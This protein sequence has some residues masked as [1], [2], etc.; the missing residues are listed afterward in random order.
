MSLALHPGVSLGPFSLG[1]V[2]TEAIELISA[3]YHSFA[4]GQI[5]YDGKQAAPSDVLLQIPGLGVCLRFEQVTQQLRRIDFWP[6]EFLTVT[7]KTRVVGCP[8]TLTSSIAGPL[9][10]CVVC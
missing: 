3:E 4:Q 1:M 8:T 5:V 10:R 6:S 7:Y 9:L 2:V